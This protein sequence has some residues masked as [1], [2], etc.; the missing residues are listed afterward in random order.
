MIVIVQ[1]NHLHALQSCPTLVLDDT[2]INKAPVQHSVVSLSVTILLPTL[3]S[4]ILIISF[5]IVVVISAASIIYVSS[6]ISSGAPFAF[7]KISLNKLARDLVLRSE[8]I[9]L[10]R[11]GESIACTDPQVVET[12]FGGL[13]NSEI[14]KGLMLF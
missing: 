12:F 11:Q 10:A 13:V 9:A 2:S 4:C 14:F 6:L 8:A 3:F 7:I 1:R 5:P